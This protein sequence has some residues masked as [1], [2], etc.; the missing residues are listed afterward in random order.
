MNTAE[1]VT[2][3]VNIRNLE[4][5]LQIYGEYRIHDMPEQ[6]VVR[7]YNPSQEELDKLG[8]SKLKAKILE[9]SAQEMEGAKTADAIE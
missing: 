5:G 8:Y 4:A 1:R 9:K 7:A 2:H 3:E 6:N